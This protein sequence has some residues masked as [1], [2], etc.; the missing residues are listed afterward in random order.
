M[1]FAVLVSSLALTIGI[2]IYDLVVRELQLTS[3]AEQSQY[4]IFAAKTAEGCALYWNTHY[5]GNKS[6]FPLSN[7]DLDALNAT[8]ALCAGVDVTALRVMTILANGSASTMK[9]V[10]EFEIGTGYA[11]LTVVRQ[12]IPGRVSTTIESQG[13]NTSDL[14]S[15]HA[16]ERKLQTVDY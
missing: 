4:A 1:F 10:I 9:T 5:A 15:P 14:T 2:A 11:I 6:I 12:G 16:V 3:V 13:Y 7:S 8:N